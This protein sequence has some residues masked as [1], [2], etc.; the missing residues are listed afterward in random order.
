MVNRS[1]I[2]GDYDLK[3]FEKALTVFDDRGMK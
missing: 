2:Y 1:M 3:K